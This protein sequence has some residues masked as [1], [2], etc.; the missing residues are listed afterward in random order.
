MMPPNKGTLSSGTVFRLIFAGSVQLS[1]ACLLYSGIISLDQPGELEKMTRRTVPEL[2]LKGEM[3]MP[4]ISVEIGKLSE[5]EKAALIEKLSLTAAQITNI[6]LGAFTVVINE[7]SDNN[8]G[9]G[10]KSIGEL[11]AQ[12]SQK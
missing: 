11:K 10:G 5:L 1:L 2:I 9:I 3:N 12:A 4:V 8:I 6:P 7:L